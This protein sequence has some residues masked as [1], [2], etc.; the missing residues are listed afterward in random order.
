MRWLRSSPFVP[1]SHGQPLGRLP[2]S[3]ELVLAAGS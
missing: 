2:L 1:L 3:A